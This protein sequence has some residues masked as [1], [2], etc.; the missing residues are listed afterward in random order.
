[1]ATWFPNYITYFI[2]ANGLFYNIAAMGVVLTNQNIVPLIYTMLDSFTI[3]TPEMWAAAQA[4]Q[5]CK[6]V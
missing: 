6:I 1:L 4:E 2:E 5:Q 3:Y